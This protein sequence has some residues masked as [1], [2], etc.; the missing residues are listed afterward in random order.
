MG[1]RQRHAR[2]VLRRRRASRARGARSR[3]RGGC[4]T[5]ARRSSTSA[6]SRRGPGA[7]GVSADE[8]LRRVVPVLEGLAG[9]PV[10]IDTSKAEVARRALELGA[11]L[12]NDVTALRGDP[13]LAG[14]VADAGAYV[15]L[16]HMRGEPRT[17]QAD[18]RLRRR[19][20]GGE[21]VPRGAARVRGRRGDPRGARLPRPG[22]RLRQDGRAQ[23]RARAAARRA[24]RDRAAGARRASRARAR[25]ARI[26]GDPAATTGTTAASVG[27][28]VAAYERGATIFRVHDVRE[29]VEAL[30]V[31]RGRRAP[32]ED[33]AARPRALRPPRRRP[34]RSASAGQLFLYDVE[35]E[36]GERGAN[37]RIE[38]AVD[39]REVAATVREVAD[40]PLRAARGARDR[41]RRRART[42]ASRRARAGA[43]P[44][45]GGAPGRDRR[46]V[47]GRHGRAARD[48]RLRRARREPRRPRGGDP[49]AR[50]SCSARRGS[51]RSARPSRG[52][53]STSRA[54][55]NAVAELETELDAA[56]SCSTGCS[57]SSA[58][59]AAC[60]TGRAGGRAR[61]TSTCCST[62]TAT[63]DEPGLTVPHPR[64][65]ERLFVLE[66]LAELAPDAR[67]PGPRDAWRNCSQGYN[68]RRE[69]PRRARRL[70]GRAR[71]P[72]QEGVQRGLLALPLLRADAGRDVPL[73]QARPAVRAA[74]G[75][76]VLPREDGG[77]LGLGQ[78]PPDPDDPARRGLHLRPT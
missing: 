64:L 7:G 57:R 67:R 10:S 59:S 22:H 33:R 39:Y 15:C 20:L 11:E 18:P 54:F 44:Q 77:R 71:A 35:L 25:S 40:R 50:R 61:S 30:R 5:T 29:H 12:V 8:E 3:R 48:A 4:S 65:H 76:P 73:Q 47:R 41:D 21:G 56:R 52:G 46:R 62:A 78:E 6:A 16:M 37:D 27:A 55:L 34:R 66:P 45:A 1:V 14:V 58:S 42:S 28:A 72:P 43:R 13:E 19:R 69:P 53:S 32:D 74:A 38:D 68:R 9:A 49:R 24:G 63:I 36:V 75:V 26:L 51:R 60:A 2:L 31:A 70:R 23:L 17:M